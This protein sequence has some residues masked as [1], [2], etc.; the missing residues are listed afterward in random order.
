MTTKEE[1]QKGIQNPEENAENPEEEK[2]EEEEPVDV[3]LQKEMKGI[4]IVD[5]D[6]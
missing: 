3:E 1:E 4:K 5:S 6:F 2:E